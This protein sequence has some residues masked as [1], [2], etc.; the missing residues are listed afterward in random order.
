MLRLFVTLSLLLATATAAL[1]PQGVSRLLEF[2]PLIDPPAALLD[3]RPS[4]EDRSS[5]RFLRDRNE[6]IL[7]VPETTTLGEFLRI[8]RL[9]DETF[10]RQIVEQLGIMT[11]DNSLSL[12]AGTE[13]RLRLTPEASPER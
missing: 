6:V 8:R 9:R 2:S 10:R 1:F 4:G 11:A 13:L 3:E 5:P 7:T 12:E